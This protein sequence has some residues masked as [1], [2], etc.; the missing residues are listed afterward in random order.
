LLGPHSHHIDWQPPA[1]A[2]SNPYLH[3]HASYEQRKQEPYQDNGDIWRERKIDGMKV[4]DKPR[5]PKRI[6]IAIL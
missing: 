3:P 1:K 6:E 2:D 4:K 5:N